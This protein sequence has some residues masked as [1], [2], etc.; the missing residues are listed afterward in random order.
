MA[1]VPQK[2]KCTVVS[3]QVASGQ[4]ALEM[5]SH[6]VVLHGHEEGVEDNTDGDGKVDKWV[7]DNQ[8]D[9]MLDLQPK[10]KALPDEEDVGKFVPA[11]RTLP[12]RLLQF[13]T[14]RNKVVEEEGLGA[15]DIFKK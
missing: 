4:D 14:V 13:C 15:C 5:G 10:W 6:R 7:H 9:D 2:R 8:V 3:N 12:L 11:G 1:V